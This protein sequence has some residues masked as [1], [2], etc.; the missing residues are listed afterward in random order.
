MSTWQIYDLRSAARFD[1]LPAT[2]DRGINKSREFSR[3]SSVF[4][5]GGNWH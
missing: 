4:H 5:G 2:L 1:A 3:V